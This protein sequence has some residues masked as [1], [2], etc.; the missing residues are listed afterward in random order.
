VCQIS[1][2]VSPVNSVFK[3]VPQV[4]PSDRFYDQHMEYQ[5]NAEFWHTGILSKIFMGLTGQIIDI[6][7]FILGL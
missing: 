6:A 4:L 3:F 1:T 2:F 7:S 5:V